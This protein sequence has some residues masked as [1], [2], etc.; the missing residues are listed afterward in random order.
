MKSAIKWLTVLVALSMLWG[1]ASPASRHDTPAAHG[2]VLNASEDAV[3]MDLGSVDRITTGSELLVYRSTLVGSPKQPPYY[4]DNP[5]GT[6]RVEHVV[7]AHLASAKLVNGSAAKGEWVE[8]P[9]S[10]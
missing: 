7:S 8:W 1:C 3:L 2:R 9:Q 6:L 10:K 4:T 5:H